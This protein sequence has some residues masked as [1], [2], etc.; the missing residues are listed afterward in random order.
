[1]SLNFSDNLTLYPNV[2]DPY[3]LGELTQSIE[4]EFD[5]SEPQVFFFSTSEGLFK[6]DKRLQD[7]NPTKLDTVGLN[8]P[9]ALSMSDKGYLLAGFSC[10]SI[11]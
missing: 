4:I 1:M 9:T 11:T 5:P 6:V 7:P 10:G 3:S 2:F 8:S